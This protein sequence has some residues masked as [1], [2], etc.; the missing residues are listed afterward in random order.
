M[1]WAGLPDLS[2]QASKLSNRSI[3]QSVCKEDKH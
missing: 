1:N 2:T 3:D